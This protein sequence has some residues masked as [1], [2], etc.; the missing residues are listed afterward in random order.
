MNTGIFGTVAAAVSQK[1][2]TRLY[3]REYTKHYGKS[4]AKVIWNTHLSDLIKHASKFKSDYYLINNRNCMND[5]D[6][7]IELFKIIQEY[8]NGNFN[9]ENIVCYDDDHFGAYEKLL[10]EKLKKKYGD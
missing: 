2:K 1:K 3:K 8:N 6:F 7:A 5:T 9:I 10:Y 4:D